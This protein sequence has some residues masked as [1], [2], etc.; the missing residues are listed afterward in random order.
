MSIN[1][2]NQ[3]I[4]SQ[5]SEDKKYDHSSNKNDLLVSMKPLENSV[6]KGDDVNFVI[7]VTDSDSQPVAD[8][9]NIWK[10]DIS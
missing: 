2:P 8:V 3:P 9:K 7:T 10:Y 4:Y 6:G 5:E 1:V